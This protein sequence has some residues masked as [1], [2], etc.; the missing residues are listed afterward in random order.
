VE[1]QGP[2]PEGLV[3][4]GVEAEDLLALPKKPVRGLLVRLVGVAVHGAHGEIHGHEADIEDQADADD[5]RQP[6]ESL[7]DRAHP[8]VDRRRRPP[9]TL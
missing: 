6:P 3:A 7:G 4:E 1:L 2:A 8:R 9:G 5:Q